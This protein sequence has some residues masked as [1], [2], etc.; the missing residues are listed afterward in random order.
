MTKL[1]TKQRR[2]YIKS[3]GDHCPYCNYIDIEYYDVVGDSRIMVCP[4]CKEKWEETYGVVG[5]KE[6]EE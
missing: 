4:E 5:I 3:D 2:D 6:Y 1:T